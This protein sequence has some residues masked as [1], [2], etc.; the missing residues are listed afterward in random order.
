VQCKNKS[1]IANIIAT[2][3][4]SKSFTKITPQ[5]TGKARNKGNAESSHIGYGTHTSV[6]S[7]VK[8]TTFN[9]EN[10]MRCII[11]GNHRIAALAP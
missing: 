6:N 9:M 10:N 5:H 1:D 7:N 4:N 11:N 3:T 2:G 8:Y